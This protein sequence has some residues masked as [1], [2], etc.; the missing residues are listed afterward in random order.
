VTENDERRHPLPATPGGE[1]PAVNNGPEE[2][3]EERVAGCPDALCSAIHSVRVAAQNPVLKVLSLCGDWRIEHRGGS[4]TVS[5]DHGKTLH[6]AM[7]YGSLSDDSV[8]ASSVASAVALVV[9]SF[10]DTQRR[11]L[12][13]LSDEAGMLHTTDRTSCES[14][15][16]LVPVGDPETPKTCCIGR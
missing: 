4:T 9:A 1:Q 13:N 10:I 7:G 16:E 6:P 11:H 8:R 12:A 2:L 15:Q 3:T 5:F 14:D